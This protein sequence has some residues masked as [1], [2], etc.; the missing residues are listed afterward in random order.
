M[1]YDIEMDMLEGGKENEEN[2]KADDNVVGHMIDHVF[3][4][5][6]TAVLSSFLFCVP[7]S[8]FIT[9]L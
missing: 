3:V 4:V 7:C 2:E 5:P 8:P 9:P 1:A 6:P